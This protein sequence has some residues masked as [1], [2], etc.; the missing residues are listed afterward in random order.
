MLD[1][2]TF[3]DVEELEPTKAQPFFLIST[4][5]NWAQETS[6]LSTQLDSRA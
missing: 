3:K 6:H 4:A 1:A 2:L 5:L